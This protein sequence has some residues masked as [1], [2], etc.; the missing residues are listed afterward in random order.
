MKVRKYIIKVKH[1]ASLLFLLIN[2]NISVG[3]A[4]MVPL[5]TPPVA[6]LYTLYVTYTF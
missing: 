2:A 6:I 1:F 3:T 4:R 5:G